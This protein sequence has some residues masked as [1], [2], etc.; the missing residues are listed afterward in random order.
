MNAVRISNKQFIVSSS[1]FIMSFGIQNKTFC[2]DRIVCILNKNLQHWKEFK[3][4][5]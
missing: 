4:M 2:I 1:N 3:Y 5:S